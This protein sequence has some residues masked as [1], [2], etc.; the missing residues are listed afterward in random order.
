M[1]KY[2][3]FIFKNNKI[4]TVI[5]III[6]LFAIIGI[7]QIKLNTDFSS[8]A[9]NKSIYEDRLN[10]A[11]QVFG[12]FNELVVVVQTDNLDTQTFSDIRVIQSHF[13]GMAKVDF[14][15]GPAPATIQ[16]GQTSINYSD[17]TY[18]QLTN[19]YSVFGNFS[20]LKTVDGSNY[21]IYTLFI[22]NNFTRHDINDMETFLK[23]FSYQSFISGDTYNQLKIGDYIIRILL[24]LPPLAILVIFLVF[25]WQ[26][27]AIKATVLSVLPAAIGALWTFGLI[28]W[29][30]HE[31]SLLTAVVPIFVI[32]IGSA[33]GLHFMSH[34]QDSRRDG[35]NSHEALTATLKIVGI[36]MIITTLTSIAGFLSLLSIRN[37]SLQQLSIFAG[38]GI[39]LAGI[40]TWLVL[41]LLLSHNIDVSRKSDKPHRLDVSKFIKKLI[42]IP[43]L[44]IVLA[45]IV[46]SAFFFGKINNEFNILMMY[47]NYTVVSKNAQKIDEINGGSIPI[48]VIITPGTNVLTTSEADKVTNLADELSAM[49]EVNKVMNPY[50]LINSL[51][52][53]ISGSD[54]TSNQVLQ[55][56]YQNAVSSTNSPLTQMVSTSDNVI[57]LLIYPRDMKNATLTTIETAVDNLSNNAEVTGVQYLMKDLNA[58]IMIMQIE[59]ILLA[60]G[61]VY[62][63]LVVSL[64]SLKLAF[65]SILPIIVTVISLYGFLG[66][67]GISLN[68]T[69]VII[70]SIT[71]GVGIDY[72]VHFSSVYKYYL[73]ETGDNKTAIDMAYANT[74]RPIIANAMGICLGLTVLMFSPLTIHFNVSILMWVSMV[75]SVILTL[76]LLPMIFGLKNKKTTETREAK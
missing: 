46:V 3:D 75:V 2:T 58:S 59:S 52:K 33:D 50:A 11:N 41:P 55:M 7:I 12:D 32:V 71:I 16:V 22:N 40:A 13:E 35:M 36:P 29:L 37:E 9:L 64:R 6:N 39:L 70:F 24:I 8:F 56:V 20:P 73:K 54:I 45:I 30:G 63:M 72:A 27:R 1:K 31:V 25:R 48:Y 38:V 53:S 18:A 62:L 19:Y 26:M 69:T 61:V 47:K 15:S 17:A 14:V 4:L 5:F 74:S 67:T 57:R 60:L 66:I 21:F 34:Y 49:P 44:V 43:S 65:Y 76:T 28:G 23:G 10:Y 68:V 42:G 51:Y